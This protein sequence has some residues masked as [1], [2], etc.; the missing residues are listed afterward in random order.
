MALAL[1]EL[2][3]SFPGAGGR[4]AHTSL[5]S[6]QPDMIETGA[7]MPPSYPQDRQSELVELARRVLAALGFWS[8]AFHV[9]VKYTSRGP[10]LIE[11]NAR[12][13][14]TPRERLERRAALNGARG[15]PPLDGVVEYVTLGSG[16]RLFEHLAGTPVVLGNP[17]VIPGIGVT[18]LRYPVRKA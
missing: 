7:Q 11:V 16:V 8:G 17:T 13:A 6:L 5:C 4:S 18:H 3:L 12:R 9:E 1:S 2:S 10:R 15:C 14:S